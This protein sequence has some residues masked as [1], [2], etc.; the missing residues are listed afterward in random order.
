LIRNPVTFFDDAVIR[1]AEQL[2][3]RRPASRYQR[4]KRTVVSQLQATFDAIRNR[5]V[6]GCRFMQRRCQ[7][8]AARKKIGG[9]GSQSATLVGLKELDVCDVIQFRIGDT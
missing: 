7:H 2:M 4:G 8:A 1:G 5:N 9:T 6:I 3:R